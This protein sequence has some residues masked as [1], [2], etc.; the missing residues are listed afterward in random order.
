VNEQKAA[1]EKWHTANTGRFRCQCFLL[2]QEHHHFDAIGRASDVKGTHDL[3][4]WESVVALSVRPA[5][6]DPEISSKKEKKISQDSDE[7][8]RPAP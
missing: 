6:V 7:L 5:W 2:E 1:R 8:G 4:P 3:S